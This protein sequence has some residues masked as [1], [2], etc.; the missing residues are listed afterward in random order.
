MIYWKHKS[1]SQSFQEICLNCPRFSE[2]YR[3]SDIPRVQFSIFISET[4]LQKTSF[5]SF[6]SCIYLYMFRHSYVYYML[7][8]YL[9]KK[10]SKWICRKVL[11]FLM[12]WCVQCMVIQAGTGLWERSVT[13]KVEFHSFSRWPQ[14]FISEELLMFFILIHSELFRVFVI[15]FYSPSL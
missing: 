3:L 6:S 12:D 9:S 5:F 13:W 1:G 4:I 14:N 15:S 2:E 8:V 7:C 11:G 10:R